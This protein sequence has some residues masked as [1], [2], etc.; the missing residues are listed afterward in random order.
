MRDNFKENLFFKIFLN[1]EEEN[2]ERIE[3]EVEEV[4]FVIYKDEKKEKFVLILR[5]GKRKLRW[6]FLP[7]NKTNKKTENN[8]EKKNLCT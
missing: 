2:K 7:K 6:R 3:V 1:E 4:I 5:V 8:H